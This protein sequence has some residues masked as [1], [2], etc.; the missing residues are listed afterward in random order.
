[1]PAL[2]DINDE[3][4]SPAKKPKAK[5]EPR[6][7]VP[8]GRL[9]MAGPNSKKAS[10]SKKTDDA[11]EESGLEDSFSSSL[12]AKKFVAPASFSQLEAPST[13]VL[14][15]GD[16]DDDDDDDDNSSLSEVGSDICDASTQ[17]RLDQDASLLAEAA[18]KITTT[19]LCPWCQAPVEKSLLEGFAKGKRLNVRMQARFCQ[20]HKKQTALATWRERR[21]PKVDWERLEARFAAH[22]GRLL[23]IINGGESHYRAKLAGRIELGQARDMKKEE[24]LNPGYY[25]PRGF[26]VMCDYMVG[27]FGDLLKEKAVGDRVIAGRGSAAFIQSVLVAELA[28]QLIREDLGVSAE[29]AREI[30]EESKA[31]GD[32]VHEE[33]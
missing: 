26:N 18:R 12:P 11:A 23:G 1:M 8:R 16:S 17:A 6:I 28:V 29:S 27:E 14:E 2:S 15:P 21:Y 3:D 30:L 7:R 19:T 31:L 25:G 20:S 24:N 33:V 13:S 5:A 9:G 10:K 4:F 22:R 32:M